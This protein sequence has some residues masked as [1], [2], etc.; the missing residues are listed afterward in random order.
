[1][2]IDPEVRQRGATSVDA[3]AQRPELSELLDGGNMAG[4]FETLAREARE[5]A[6]RPRQGSRPA[7][8]EDPDRGS[9]DV[10]RDR[11]TLERGR[12]GE[13][14]RREQLLEPALRD[15]D[16]DAVPTPFGLSLRDAEARATRVPSAGW[17][18]P[19]DG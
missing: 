8:P 18:C 5:R 12:K 11:G 19:T 7:G 1:M 15:D 6:H 14:Q 10:D 3:T 17:D 9:L 2:R 4:R 13:A 16:G